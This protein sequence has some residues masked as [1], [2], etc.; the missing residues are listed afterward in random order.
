MGIKRFVVNLAPTSLVKIFAGPYVAG[1]SIEA[2]VDTSKN[3]WDTRKV[4][5]TVDL[6]GEEIETDEEVD[7]TVGV[8]ERLIEALGKQEYATISL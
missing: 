8:Y 6:L 5:S 2:A 4:C 7:Y 3:F 1:D